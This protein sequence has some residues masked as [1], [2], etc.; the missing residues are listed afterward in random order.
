VDIEECRKKKKKRIK[1]KLTKRGKGELEYI[2][3]F[4]PNPK[5]KAKNKS[6]CLSRETGMLKQP[7]S[8]EKHPQDVKQLMNKT[9]SLAKKYKNIL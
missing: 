1:K 8:Q 3:S 4:R 2:G 6:R 5:K 7:N 9:G